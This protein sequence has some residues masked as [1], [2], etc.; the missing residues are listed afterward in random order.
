MFGILVGLL[1]SLAYGAT[2]G[3]ARATLQPLS[4]LPMKRSFSADGGENCKISFET[5]RNCNRVGQ[6]FNP[7]RVMLEAL[8]RDPKISPESITAEF[9]NHGIDMPESEWKRMHDGFINLT[10]VPEW[11]HALLYA[12]TEGQTEEGPIRARLERYMQRFRTPQSYELE[13]K[14][15]ELW[16]MFC[17][18]PLLA[19]NAMDV[20]CEAEP[21]ETLGAENLQWTLSDTVKSEVFKREL[22]KFTRKRG[23]KRERNR[24]E[25]PETENREIPNEQLQR[26]ILESLI[27]DPNV[28]EEDV[29]H[30]LGHLGEARVRL[31]FRELD[32][33]TRVPDWFQ[34][35]LST[36]PDAM[37][38]D[39]ADALLGLQSIEFDIPGSEIEAGQKR[40]ANWRTFGVRSCE[41]DLENPGMWVMTSEAKIAFFQSIL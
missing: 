34:S 14:R 26:L 5:K 13:R 41:R 29:L 4:E 33:L 20:P 11:L 24:D 39:T 22:E 9:E 10:W 38:D 7:E 2:Y 23:V 21:S 36:V 6:G 16:I 18:R 32:F 1:I 37:D 31:I 25:F 19:E 40:I 17:V 27:G 12:L 15:I 28:K 35:F 8:V 30:E 3:P